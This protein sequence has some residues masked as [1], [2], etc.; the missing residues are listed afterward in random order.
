MQCAMLSMIRITMHYK[1]PLKSLD[2]NIG[3]SFD[4]R[5]PPVVILS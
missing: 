1:E 5:I 3:H 4:S 2:K